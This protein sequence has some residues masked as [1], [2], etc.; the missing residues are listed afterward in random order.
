MDVGIIIPARLA[1]RRVPNKLL[2]ADTGKSVLQHTYEAACTAKLAHFV[3]VATD[4]ADIAAMVR[5]FGGVAWKTNCRHRTGTDRIAE[6]KDI[7]RALDII[8]NVQGDEP[9]I[10][11]SQIDQVIYELQDRPHVGMATL[12]TPCRHVSELE[13]GDLVKVV[14]DG[15]QR[16]LFF[17]RGPVPYPCQSIPASG[18]LPPGW[19]R[20]VG[21]YAYRREALLDLATEGK[22]R[23]RVFLESEE[24][25]EQMRAL[26]LGMTIH[27]AHVLRA[28]W[29]IKTRL[30]YDRF[31]D[32]W[33][34]GGFAPH[35][36][37]QVPRGEG[38]NQTR[39][40]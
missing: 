36:L 7:L 27:V 40:G 18:E 31:V 26:H 37:R 2:L 21:V 14:F 39:R 28:G 29:A 32:W 13:D 38:A 35:A 11:G 3:G 6:K 12:A 22:R 19:W 20:H 33:N 1:S 5:H 30:D 17:S 24:S 23:A 16:A 25:L 9:M 15:E 34:D 8:V 10:T 4:S